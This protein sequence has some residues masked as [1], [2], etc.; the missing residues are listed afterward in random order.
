MILTATI[1][2]IGWMLAH[3]SVQLFILFLA[4]SMHV[5]GQEKW[6]PVLADRPVFFTKTTPLRDLTPIPPQVSVAGK[7]EVKNENAPPWMTGALLKEPAE[8]D[9][10]L[11]EQQGQQD[12]GGIIANFE[13]V[14]NVQNKIPPDTEGDIGPDHYLQMINMSFAVFD[15]TGNILY[16]PAANVTIWQNTPTPWADVS[17]GDPIALYDRTA[18]RWLISELS[19]PHHPLGPYYV[20]IAVSVTGDP[21]GSWYLYGFEYDYFCDYPK[22]GIWHDGYYLTT[23]N[24]EWVNSQWDFHAVGLSVFERDS[25]LAGSPNAQRFFY[26]FYPNQQYWSMLPADVDGTPPP[27]SQ[28][29]YLACYK[30][31]TP[32]KIFIFGVN[33]D[34]QNINN[35]TVQLISTLLPSPFSGNLPNGVS[36]PQGAPYLASL[37]NRLMYRLQYRTFPDYQCLVANHTVNR[38]D[39]VA[40]IRWYEFR[41]AGSGWEIYQEGTYSP[42]NEH[43]WMGS[44]AMDGYGNMALGYSVS[45]TSVFPSIRYTGRMYDDPPGVMTLAEGVIMDG[46]GV[47]L[48]S[49]HRWGDYSSMSIDPVDECTFWYTQQYYAVTGDRTWQTRIASLHLNDYLTL[50]VAAGA[51]TLCAGDSL[52]LSAMPSGGSGNYS[53]SWESDPQGF[54]SS[55]QNPIVFPVVN[56]TYSCTVYDGLNTVTEEVG[57]VVNP[58]PVVYA[59]ADTLIS[60][61]NTYLIQDS[62]AEHC[63]GLEWATQG[64]GYFDDNLILHPE[65][66]PGQGDISAGK[67]TLSLTGFPLAACDAVTDSM[68][69]FIDPATDL[70]EKIMTGEEVN[71]ITD[72]VNKRIFVDCG[73]CRKKI[74]GLKV[75][76]LLGERLG[77]FPLPENNDRGAVEIDLSRLQGG[78]YILSVEFPE[79]HK[80]FKLVL[81]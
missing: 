74:T 13:G 31:G 40:G 14:D 45:S 27:E 21:L 73:G 58:A 70:Q 61:G 44:I 75:F 22:F 25:M 64:D 23:N 81:R 32:D 6:S 36:Q 24:N 4:F 62:Q 78:M 37:S 5:V 42:D 52:Q 60:A 72:Q 18:D 66:T 76:N 50:T 79:Y 33:T 3:A 39:G 68:N 51:D 77:A 2:K 26:D 34:W 10:V 71:I 63:L 17:N 65:Y 11:Q 20:K 38:G 54:Q 1:R 57:I 46:T 80:A 9:P 48:N 41:D 55:L 29:C 56:T 43:R 7:E 59:G 30:E 19:F 28:P 47:Q 12:Y 16:G 69:L 15:R 49:S 35:S 53:F 8:P 67:A